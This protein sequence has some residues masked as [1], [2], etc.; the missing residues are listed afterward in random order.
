[1]KSYSHGYTRNHAFECTHDFTHAVHN[2]T[3]HTHAHSCRNDTCVCLFYIW[4]SVTESH[5]FISL[6]RFICHL[7]YLSPRQAL[8]R[9]SVNKSPIG[10]IGTQNMYDT[11]L[12]PIS[13]ES[14]K[15]NYYTQSRFMKIFRICIMHQSEFVRDTDTEGCSINTFSMVQ[16]R[17]LYCHDTGTGTKS[18]KILVV[19]PSLPNDNLI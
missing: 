6:F 18:F 11:T 10:C 8:L 5:L 9:L 14:T 16:V 19:L 15:H 2:H 1:M 17:V 12:I 7:F 13:V 4:L 3:S